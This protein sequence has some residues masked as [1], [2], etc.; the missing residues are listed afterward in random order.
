MKFLIL[1]TLIHEKFMSFDTKTISPST[2]TVDP[3]DV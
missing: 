3:L 2:G 1:D